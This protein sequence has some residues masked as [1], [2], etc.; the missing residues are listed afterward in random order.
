MTRSLPSLAQLA[1]RKSGADGYALL[2]LDTASG[3]FVAFHASGAAVPEGF[4]CTPGLTLSGGMSVASYS[5]H[6]HGAVTGLLAFS[7]GRAA[8]PEASL[9][10]LD[11]MARVIESVYG[12]PY[13]MARLAS[14]VS[15]LETELADVKIAERVRGLLEDG[16][17]NIDTV[18]IVAR[19]VESVQRGRQASAF[20][21]QMLPDLEDR[22]Q[23]RKL[24][25]Q[26]KALL[27]RL[28]GMSEEQAYL[29]LRGASRASRKRLGEVA[30]DLVEVHPAGQLVA[31]SM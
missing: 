23:E 10:V 25:I 18:E 24:V 27:Q 30:R 28:H 19:H 21:E 20:L 29:Y 7:F 6:T 16:T 9:A 22:V 4:R 12:L 14:R 15:D 3:R 8:V 1:V 31:G 13:D 11:R 2:K 17:E 26:A 5:L